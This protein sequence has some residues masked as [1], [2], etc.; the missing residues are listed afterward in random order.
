MTITV[1]ND[2]IFDT[3]GEFGKW[4]KRAMILVFSSKI[5]ACWCMAII[6]FTAPVPEPIEIRCFNDSSH[7]TNYLS[8]ESDDFNATI[9]WHTASHPEL[10]ISSD[11]YFDIDFCS[12]ESDIFAHIGRHNIN[13]TSISELTESPNE[14]PCSEFRHRPF[15]RDKLTK[16]DWSCSRNLIGAFTQFFFLFGVLIGG[17]IAWRL[18]NMLVFCLKTAQFDL[19]AAN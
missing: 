16:F 19:C 5:V 10:V 13:S 2:I 18:L 12:V 1:Q 11:K 9:R 7:S 17:I 14:V 4:Q 3:V 15:F 6:L 8:S